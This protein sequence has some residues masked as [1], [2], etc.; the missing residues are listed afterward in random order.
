MATLSFGENM[1]E[2]V[3]MHVVVI[4]MK[5]FKGTDL[6]LI[7]IFTRVYFQPC[8]THSLSVRCITERRG[9]K[10]IFVRN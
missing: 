3:G 5:L 4:Q 10:D 2:R 8:L 1:G 9:R 7:Y 6:F